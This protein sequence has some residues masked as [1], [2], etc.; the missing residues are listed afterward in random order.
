MLEGIRTNSDSSVVAVYG[1]VRPASARYRKSR[2]AAVFA[3]SG[4]TLSQWPATYPFAI[5]AATSGTG[6][7]AMPVR[8]DPLAAAGLALHRES[9]VRA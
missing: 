7:S 6:E 2:R 3:P 8:G 4:Q 5:A 1:T 9:S